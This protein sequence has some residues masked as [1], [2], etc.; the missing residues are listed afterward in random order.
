MDMKA[1]FL[2]EPDNLAEWGKIR[3]LSSHDSMI[4]VKEA[5]VVCFTSKQAAQNPVT[6]GLPSA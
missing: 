5:P 4:S 2:E 1:G 3:K 6:I